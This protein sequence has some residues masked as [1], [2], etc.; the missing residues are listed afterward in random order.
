MKNKSII[1]MLLLFWKNLFLFYFMINIVTSQECNILSPQ[2]C[3]K[4]P[5]SCSLNFGE[6]ITCTFGSASTGTCA[7]YIGQYPCLYANCTYYLPANYC[8]PSVNDLFSVFSCSNSGWTITEII[9]ATVLPVLAG[10]G[11]I[12]AIIAKFPQI[13]SFLSTCTKQGEQIYQFRQKRRSAHV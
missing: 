12:A 9:L 10:G 8:F 1:S 6:Y 13:F 7:S 4:Y 11:I 3:I 5:D 2:D